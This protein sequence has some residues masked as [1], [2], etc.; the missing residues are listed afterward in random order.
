M[1]VYINVHWC[2]DVMMVC[3]CM[4]VYDIDDEDNKVIAH[5]YI[6]IITIIYNLGEMYIREQKLCSV[7]IYWERDIR[8]LGNDDS[9]YI[10][11]A[12]RTKPL[13]TLSKQIQN[14]VN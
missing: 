6:Y 2:E 8:S 7:R 14:F 11:P 3:E 4:Y 9:E 5:D 12:L 10:T 1:R 13:T